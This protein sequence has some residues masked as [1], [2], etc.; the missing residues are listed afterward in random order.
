MYTHTVVGGGL[1]LLLL[2]CPVCHSLLLRSPRRLAAES[3]SSEGNRFSN[4]ILPLSPSSSSDTKTRSIAARLTPPALDP[5]YMDDDALCVV[6]RR[7]CVQEMRK[8]GLFS[9]YTEHA[10]SLLLLLQGLK[11]I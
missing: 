5:V 10:V 1:L 7:V 3:L 4:R 9:L 2:L 6:R 11:V 8:L